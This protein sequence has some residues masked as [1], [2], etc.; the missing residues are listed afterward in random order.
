M[1]GK[2]VDRHDITSGGEKLP[3]TFNIHI[4]SEAEN[5]GTE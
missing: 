2:F 3:A 4:N 5:D 1:H